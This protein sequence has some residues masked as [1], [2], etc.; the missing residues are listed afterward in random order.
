MLGSRISN[1]GADAHGITVRKVVSVCAPE[2]DGNEG[3]LAKIIKTIAW[4]E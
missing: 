2:R 3:E 4:V 1:P